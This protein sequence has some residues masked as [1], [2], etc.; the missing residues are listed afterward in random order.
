MNIEGDLETS[1]RVVDLLNVKS[2]LIKR[3]ECRLDYGLGEPYIVLYPSP[4]P[5]SEKSTSRKLTQA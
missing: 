5:Q 1:A 4:D 2:R 3:E